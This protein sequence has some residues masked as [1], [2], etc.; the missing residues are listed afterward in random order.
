MPRYDWGYKNSIIF[1]HL[2]YKSQEINTSMAL[3]QY[4]ILFECWHPV[5]CVSYPHIQ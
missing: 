2:N 4:H 1:N 3:I 5:I